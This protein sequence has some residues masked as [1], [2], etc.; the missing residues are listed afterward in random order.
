MSALP[1]IEFTGARWSSAVHCPRRAVFDHQDA[2]KDPPTEQQRRWWRR[3]HAIERVIR[4][5]VFTELHEEGR[6]PRAQEIIPWPAADPI[7]DSHLD[8]YVP[9]QREAIE[10]KSNGGAG[11]TA[12][13]AIQVAGN[14]LNHPNA[15][16]AQVCS[17][18]SNSF[19]ERWYPIDV[20]GLEAQVREIEEKVVRGVRTGELPDRVCRHPGDSPAFLCP[21]VEHCFSDWKRPDRDVSLLDEEVVVLAELTDDVGRA[22]A[23]LAMAETAMREHRETLRPYLEPGVELETPSIA[24]L[25]VTEIAARETLSLSD[26]KK[27]GVSLPRK[28]RPFVKIGQP[29]ERWTIRRRESQ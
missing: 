29:S 17:V 20:S 27:A 22:R 4:E 2:P 25:Q 10:V 12:A 21:Y 9:H 28:L 1:E 7:G 15:E 11:L 23:T 3:G 14:C 13:A 16:T 24:K 8:I 18:D 19:E 26:L 5:Q 6:R